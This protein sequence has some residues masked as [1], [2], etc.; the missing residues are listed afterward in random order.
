MPWWLDL[1]LLAGA[2]LLWS[3]GCRE[4]DDTI[5]L[6]RKILAVVAVMVVLLGGRQVPLEIAVLT[7]ALLLPSASRCE[8][9][10]HPEITDPLRR[11]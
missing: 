3:E 6:L 7:L 11:D 5:G 2:V 10:D 1:V 8:R 4:V 9:R